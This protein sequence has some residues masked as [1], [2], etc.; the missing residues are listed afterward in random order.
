MSK[1][2]CPRGYY[3]SKGVKNKCPAGSFGQ[4]M[5]L[6][7]ERCDGKCLPGFYCPSGS[8]SN[9]QRPCG[10]RTKFC[11]LGSKVPRA[12]IS[13][14]YTYNNSLVEYGDAQLQ[15]STMSWQKKCEIGYYCEGGVKYQCPAGTFGH[16][17][18]M[19]SIDNCLPCKR[20]ESILLSR[21][22]NV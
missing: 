8:V 7:D 21:I 1:I 15:S 19:S 5:G 17:E 18:G 11:P 3:C 4:T 14:F 6:G 9:K 20:G 22:E 13:G 16:T 2:L 12:V 10:D